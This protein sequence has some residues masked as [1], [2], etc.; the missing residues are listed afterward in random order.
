MATTMATRVILTRTCNSNNN[1][2]ECEM[3]FNRC[4]ANRNNNNNNNNKLYETKAEVS[5]NNGGMPTAAAAAE[6]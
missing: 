3:I 5:W 1:S 6:S 2:S 4:A